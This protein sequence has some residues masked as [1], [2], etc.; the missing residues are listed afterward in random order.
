VTV[1]DLPAGINTLRVVQKLAVGAPPDKDI[2]QSNVT[3]FH[4]R[5]VIRQSGGPN[6][7]LIQVG[8]VDH[9]VDPPVTPLTV[10]LDPVLVT[11]QTVLLLLTELSPPA[12][13]PP[14]S[15]SFEARPTQI[16]PHYATFDTWGA[17]VGDYLVRVRVDGAETELRTDPVTHAF[18]YPRVTL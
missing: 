9:S 13:Q 16:G 7:D 5:P 10:Q 1:P 3:V 8:S 18:A 14:L 6:S 15:L 11:T 4:L 12:G 2:V 17:R